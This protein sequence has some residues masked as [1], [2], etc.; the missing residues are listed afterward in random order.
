M[1][2]RHV[3]QMNRAVGIMDKGDKFTSE[4]DNPMVVSL[5]GAG[6]AD[7]VYI[8]DDDVEHSQVTEP[9]V[10]G[11]EDGAEVRG[12]PGDDAHRATEAG[13]YPHPDNL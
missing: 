6:Y 2:R 3:Y 11:G 4:P 8:G 5:V 13:V 7:L 12:E 10:R 9:V 1:T